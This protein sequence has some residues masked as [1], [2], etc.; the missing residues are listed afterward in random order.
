MARKTVE[1][2]KVIELANRMMSACPDESVDVRKGIAL[3]AE[4]IL[5]DTGN[6]NGFC[7]IQKGGE[8]VPESVICNGGNYDQT[9]RFYYYR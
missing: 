2:E 4:Q 6:Y 5:L 3:M 9:R 8:R 1:I 7:Y